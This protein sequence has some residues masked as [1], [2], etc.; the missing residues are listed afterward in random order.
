[1]A[2]VVGSIERVASIMQEISAASVEQSQGVSQI[3]DA[4]TQ[5][6]EVTQQNAALVEEMS[7]AATGL[8][9]QAKELVDSVAVFKL[10]TSGA[11]R[12]SNAGAARRAVT[13][14]QP[15]ATKVKAMLNNAAA[16]PMPNKFATEEWESF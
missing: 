2:E 1:M 9:L 12:S 8:E 15:V 16:L 7:A 3:G 14:A 6:D 11:V 10:G 5:M 4:V 13:R